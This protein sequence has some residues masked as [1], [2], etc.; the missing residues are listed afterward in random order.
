MSR[1]IA[2]MRDLFIFA[3]SNRNTIYIAALHKCMILLGS[4]IP[5]HIRHC[6]CRI[7]THSAVVNSLRRGKS[8]NCLSCDLIH[9][10]Y[11][12]SYTNRSTNEIYLQRLTFFVPS[13]THKALTWKVPA[14]STPKQSNLQP[15]QPMQVRLQHK[16]DG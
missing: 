15:P 13:G 3:K 11:P 2:A 12:H 9:A 10:L 6:M 1:T 14:T 16:Y 8:S 5:R 4:F 7:I